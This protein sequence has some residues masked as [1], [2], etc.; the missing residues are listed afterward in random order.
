[1]A[2]IAF[3]YILADSHTW[4]R[5]EEGMPK[6]KVVTG[7]IIEVDEARVN[8]MQM[9]LAGFRRV[10]ENGEAQIE[11]FDKVNSENAESTKK[12]SK[13]AKEKAKEIEKEEEK[14]AE[15][16]EV[17][18]IVVPTVETEVKEDGKTEI[19]VKVTK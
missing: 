9:Y 13:K 16:N 10:D 4:I 11:W 14:I 5:L 19:T 17:P 12:E 3:K 8:K 1:M 2:N 18:E 15:G 6:V 7:E